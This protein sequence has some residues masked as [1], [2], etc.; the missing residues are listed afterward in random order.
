MQRKDLATALNKARSK[1]GV[2][3][4][5]VA[6]VLGCSRMTV[7]RWERGKHLPQAVYVQIWEQIGEERLKT[8]A[9]GRQH[10]PTLL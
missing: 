10:G 5:D 7:N 9:K 8:M 2:T 4:R 6:K 1:Y 3:R